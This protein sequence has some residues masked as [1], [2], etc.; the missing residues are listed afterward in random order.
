MLYLLVVVIV[1]SQSESSSKTV[2]FPSGVQQSLEA[3]YH[4]TF[5]YPTCFEITNS[6]DSVND[7]LEFATAYKQYHDFHIIV[8]HLEK[9]SAILGN[10]LVF[11]SGQESS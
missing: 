8:K 11:V 7:A 1:M 6:L 3:T 4:K 9:V 5:P 10:L 2:K